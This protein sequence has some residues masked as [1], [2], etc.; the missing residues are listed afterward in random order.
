MYRLQ[1][2]SNTGTSYLWTREEGTWWSLVFKMKRH[3]M[4]GIQW[5]PGYV[6]HCRDYR[7]TTVNCLKIID[8]T[9]G[10]LSICGFEYGH[11]GFA[12][13]V[14]KQ[15]AALLQAEDKRKCFRVNQL[16]V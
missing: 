8:A 4:V 3:E 12:R 2:T 6:G 14:G 16:S 1:V 7:R 15:V 5:N 10:F 11:K 13:F 9:T